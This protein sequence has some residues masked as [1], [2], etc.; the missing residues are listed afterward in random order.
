VR[1]SVL[2]SGGL[3][4]GLRRALQ[5]RRLEGS[6]AGSICETFTQA[7]WGAVA[8]EFML[9]AAFVAS[10]CVACGSAARNQVQ[11]MPMPAQQMQMQQ[12]QMVDGAGTTH[13]GRRSANACRL[14]GHGC[15]AR[16]PARRQGRSCCHGHR[17]CAGPG[18][19]PEVL[20]QLRRPRDRQQ[21]LRR[22]RDGLGVI[23][24][25]AAVCR[26]RAHRRGGSRVESSGTGVHS[27]VRAS[28]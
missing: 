11:A 22:V 27:R 14:S 18:L 1:S 20:Q 13:A 19:G 6:C 5:H 12:M 17:S 10:A 16:R 7:L 4:P 3:P 2:D 24:A 25:S 8:F 15:P 23:A 28:Q 9:F 26:T 21:L